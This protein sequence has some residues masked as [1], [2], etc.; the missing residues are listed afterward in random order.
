M[1]IV[2][3][4]EIQM[5]IYLD[6]ASTTKPANNMIDAIRP[7]I[8][9]KWHNPSS[10]YS[11]STD[12]K[13][14]IEEVRTN[15]AKFINA[16]TEEIIFSS[17]ASESNN[18]VI[19][20]FDDI[21]HQN[22]SVIISTHLEHSSILNALKNPALMSAIWFCGVDK[23]GLVDLQHLE[24]LL[25]S[26]KRKKA[27][28]S[29]IYAQNEIGTVQRLK[30]ISRLVHSYNA[31]LHTDCTQALPHIKIDVKELGIDLMTASAHKLGGLKGTGFL[32]KAKGVELSPLIYGEQEDKRRGGTENIIGLI[33]LGEAI[34]VIDYNKY[35]ELCEKQLYFMRRLVEEFDCTIN[36]S[37]NSRLP[38]N[39]N[40]TFPQNITG[41]SLLYML[42]MSNIMVSTGSACNSKS[43]EPSHVLKAIG[44]TDDEAMKTIRI[45]LSNDI[46]YEEI[47]YVISEIGKAI[48]LI[49]I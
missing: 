18:H 20:G 49:E 40:I 27:L 16:D 9:T 34:K 46:T 33:A 29:I 48:K 44:L 23:E 1:I 45:T 37:V 42:D 10:L 35:S 38:N 19:R 21:N 2:W 4:K 36:G 47:D 12:I 15:V 14:K 5:S 25:E 17:G 41:E 6:T 30:E 43:I 28:V 3:G 7:Y 26:C 8:E 39:I 11:S 22:E 32:Y 24:V 31:I 13:K